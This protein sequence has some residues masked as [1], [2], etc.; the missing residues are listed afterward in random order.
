MGPLTHALPHELNSGNY[1]PLD[2]AP[3]N[4]QEPEWT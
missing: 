2:R 3:P 1:A 4:R